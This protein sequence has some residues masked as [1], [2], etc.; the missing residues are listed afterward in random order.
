MIKIFGLLK[1]KSDIT[2]DEFRQRWYVDHASLARK[3]IPYDIDSPCRR[4][5]QNYAVNLG[6]KK[7]PPFDAI[8]ETWWDDFE[9]IKRWADW[10]EGDDGKVLRDD[11]DRFLDKSRRVILVTDEQ[12]VK[13]R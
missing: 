12:I 8:G 4:W 13:P 2:M 10:Y 3:V 9:A 1:K 5:V 11:E 6:G 7:D